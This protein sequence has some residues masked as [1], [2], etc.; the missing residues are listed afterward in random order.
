MLGIKQV[1]FIPVSVGIQ[2]PQLEN[3]P[4]LRQL[5][6]D[7]VSFKKALPAHI[8][9]LKPDPNATKEAVEAYNLAVK[10]WNFKP[11]DLRTQ[12]E[13]KNAANAVGINPNK[14]NLRIK[15]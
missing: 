1:G 6:K 13:L 3:K 8:A 2:K 12:F 9:D 14:F 11:R 4:V 7:T 10:M 5:N 15:I